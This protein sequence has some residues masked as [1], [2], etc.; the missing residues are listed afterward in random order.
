MKRITLI[1]LISLSAALIPSLAIEASKEIPE[2]LQ[3]VLN[4]RMKGTW[5]VSVSGLPSIEM[6]EWEAQKKKNLFVHEVQPP[7]FV[8]DAFAHSFL[9]CEESKDYWIV[10]RGGIGGLFQVFGPGS[11]E[12]GRRD[13]EYSAAL[14]THVSTL[15]WTRNWVCG[16]S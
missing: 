7:L 14:H 6:E 1:F 11:L 16:Q 4:E 2:E 10:R 8:S 15:R 3:H 13:N 12:Q 9:F 5:M